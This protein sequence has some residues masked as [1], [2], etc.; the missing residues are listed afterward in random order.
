MLPKLK[1][2]LDRTVETIVES[3]T[4]EV[5]EYK[6]KEQVMQEFVFFHVMDSQELNLLSDEPLVED[7][8]LNSAFLNP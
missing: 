4:A 6:H 7:K 1:Q 2:V 8:F 3:Q 5:E